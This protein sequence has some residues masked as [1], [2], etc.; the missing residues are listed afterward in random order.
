MR[1]M[2]RGKIIIAGPC[3][4]TAFVAF[5]VL[6]TF[7][8]LATASAQSVDIIAVN[9]AFQDHYA[10]GNYPAAQIDAQELERL[11]KARFGAD[12]PY[13]AVAL[14]RLGIVVQ[15]QGKYTDAE[16]LFKRA[17]TIRENA[18]GAS[19]PDV[20]QSLNNRQLRRR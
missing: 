5:L 11:V 13:Y 20:G 1:Q 17:L 9:K 7:G 2:S 4:K 12:H 3:S 18:L 6:T 10:R 19:H 15:A 14:N 8:G 16:G